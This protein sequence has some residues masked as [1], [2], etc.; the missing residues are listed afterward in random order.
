MLLHAKLEEKLVKDNGRQGQEQLKVYTGHVRSEP[1]VFDWLLADRKGGERGPELRA[2]SSRL[3]ESADQSVLTGKLPTANLFAPAA[4]GALLHWLSGAPDHERQLLSDFAERVRAFEATRTAQAEK[5]AC[6]GLIESV[7]G[8]Y[9]E[10]VSLR[11]EKSEKKRRAAALKVMGRPATTSLDRPRHRPRHPPHLYLPRAAAS[12]AEEMEWKSLGAG[13][14]RP[15][16]APQE[17]FDDEDQ[18]EGRRAAEARTEGE[19]RPRQ[20]HDSPPTSSSVSGGHAAR[21]AAH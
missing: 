15:V 4:H 12:R 10:K 8:L 18:G 7:S 19:W 11:Q 1:Y 9:R 6:D 21:H 14:P 16:D 17:A 5:G 3:A 2:F 20:S 13:T